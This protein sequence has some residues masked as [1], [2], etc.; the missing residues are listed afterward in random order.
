M[1]NSKLGKLSLKDLMKGGITAV[2]T[3][4]LTGLYSIIDNGRMPT[5]DDVKFIGTNG[6]LAFG[7][8]IFKNLGTN[9][10]DKFL[11]KET[12]KE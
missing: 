5:M 11:G 1:K 4:V 10:E 8:Y 2:M 3:A 6:L 9:S 12:P 7:G